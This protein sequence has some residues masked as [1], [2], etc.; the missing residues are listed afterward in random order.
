MINLFMG[1]IILYLCYLLIYK[2]ETLTGKKLIFK[3]LFLGFLNGLLIANNF[4]LI[5]LSYL[6]TTIIFLFIKDKKI[7]IRINFICFLLGLFSTVLPLLWLNHFSYETLHQHINFSSLWISLKDLFLYRLPLFLGC[8]IFYW[9]KIPLYIMIL[10]KIIYFYLFLLLAYLVFFKDKNFLNFSSQKIH[11]SNKTEML[12]V[13][14]ICSL[15]LFSLSNSPQTQALY[16]LYSSL[17]LLIAYFLADLKEESKSLFAIFISLLIFINIFDNYQFVQH[18]INLEKYQPIKKIVQKLK[19]K[20][21][22]EIYTHST[23]Q[24]MLDFE[25][26][27]QLFKLHNFLQPLTETEFKKP[28]TAI[29]THPYLGLPSTNILAAFL[30]SKKIPYTRK[31]VGNHTIFYLN[32]P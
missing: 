19:H 6:V 14:F 7:F 4:L 3:F 13:H 8:Y 20:G 1:N 11:K 16:P 12:M 25:D 5:N 2:E 29:V 21:V 24:S 27:D 18:N 17:P 28:F 22:K 26:S 31:K 10:W 23:L 30:D 9:Q 32:M 15:L